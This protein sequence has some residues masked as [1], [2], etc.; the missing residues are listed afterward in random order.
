MGYGLPAAIAAKIT[1]PDRDVYSLNG[2][3]AFAMMMEEILVQVEYQ[4][5]IVNMIF[6]NETL[7]FIE[8]EQRDDTNQ[9]LS[10]VDIIETD[11]ET[12]CRGLGATTFTAHN[13]AEFKDAMNKAKDVT[14]PVVIDI[15]Y[16]HEMPFST[17][18]MF[19]DPET[20]SKEKVDAFVRKYQAQDLK[21]FTTFLK[22]SGVEHLENV[23]RPNDGFWTTHR[24]ILG[25]SETKP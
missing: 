12:A 23:Y 22:E 3:G 1:Y 6:N 21:P 2:G 11:W 15:K 10:G 13:S 20:Q 24:D 19:L 4:L 5:H 25:N 9:P 7:G 16:T 8:A 17:V 14:G 18:Y